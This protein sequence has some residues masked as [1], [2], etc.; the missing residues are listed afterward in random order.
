[1][2]HA[3][4]L[5][6]LADGTGSFPVTADE[7]GRYSLTVPPGTYIVKWQVVGSATYHDTGHIYTGRWDVKPLTV[8]AGQ[9]VVLDLTTRAFSL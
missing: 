4:E 9:R 2:A 8:R 3:T 6:E 1:M 5:F 7:T